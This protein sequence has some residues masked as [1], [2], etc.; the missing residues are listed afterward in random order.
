MKISFICQALKCLLLFSSMQGGGRRPGR[1]T[2]PGGEIKYCSI[3]M[4]VPPC[5]KKIA[6]GG[7]GKEP[8]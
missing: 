2:V 3:N 1:L 4:Q 5:L 8:L 7:L 6:Y